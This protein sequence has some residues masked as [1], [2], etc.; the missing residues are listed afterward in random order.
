MRTII[1]VEKPA[2]VSLPRFFWAVKDC[3]LQEPVGVCLIDGTW[4][5][6]FNKPHA[7]SAGY[8]LAVAL[9]E[10]CVAQKHTPDPAPVMSLLGPRAHAWGPFDPTKFKEP[11]WRA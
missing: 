2:G 10:D 7:P 3:F 4:V 9:G 11:T 6:E 8:Q 1:N 5:L